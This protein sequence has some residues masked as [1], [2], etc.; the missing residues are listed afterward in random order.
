MNMMSQMSEM[1]ISNLLFVRFIF[2]I[3]IWL[4]SWLFLVRL[5]FVGLLCCTLLLFIHRHSDLCVM[6][7]VSENNENKCS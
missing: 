5:A 7:G 1:N 6:V 3:N 4:W 2:N